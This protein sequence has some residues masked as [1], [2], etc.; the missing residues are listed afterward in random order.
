[1][2]AVRDK[3]PTF[4]ELLKEVGLSRPVL[5]SKLRELQNEGV[6]TRSI[7]GRRIE[8]KVTDRGKELEQQRMAHIAITTQ[9][10]KDLVK[11]YSDDTAKGLSLMAQI[12]REDPEHFEA[13]MQC[14]LEYN[15]LL[16]SDDFLRWVR[17]ISERYPGEQMRKYL[18]KE[19]MKRLPGWSYKPEPLS[20]PNEAAEYVDRY[21]KVVRALREVMAE[22]KPIKQTKVRKSKA[23]SR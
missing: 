16:F 18:M 19:M 17:E 13:L 20:S 7:N 15:Q 8:Y 22:D 21:Q 2:I 14:T 9:I 4:S 5:S 1:V 10:L 3:H 23:R 6:V 12:A 11:E